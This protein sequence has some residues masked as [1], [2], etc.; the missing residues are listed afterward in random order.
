MVVENTLKIALKKTFIVWFRMKIIS[1]S[2]EPD[3][4][5]GQMFFVFIFAEKK[6]GGAKW[7]AS[8]IKNSST[9]NLSVM[10]RNVW[11]KT[12][13]SRDAKLAIGGIKVY[14]M[15]IAEFRSDLSNCKVKWQTTNDCHRHWLTMLGFAVGGACLNI[16]SCARAINFSEICKYRAK[17]IRKLAW[18]LRNRN[19]NKSFA[20][21]CRCRN[22]KKF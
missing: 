21:Y 13:H 3:E 2:T 4:A 20:I 8:S 11:A 5:M 22:G 12:F 18:C 14:R 6:I 16:L 9:R 10:K 7:H 15:Q 19:S 1:R 17:G